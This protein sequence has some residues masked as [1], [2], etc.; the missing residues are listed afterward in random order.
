M[1]N[2]KHI[3]KL[4]LL[5]VF[6][7]FAAMLIQAAA[8]TQ[9]IHTP[10]ANSRISGTINLIVPVNGTMYSCNVAGCIPPFANVS[11]VGV[12]YT[13]TSPSGGLETG[14]CI[15]RSNIDNGTLTNWTCSFNTNVLEDIGTYTFTA[16]VYNGTGANLVQRNTTTSTGVTVDNFAPSAVFGA[17]TPADN[18]EQKA[19]TVTVDT[20]ADINA[21]SCTLFVGAKDY[22]V[23]PSGDVCSRQLSSLSD[24]S[25]T[26]Y[27]QTSDGLNS[28]TGATRTL[29]I[30]AKGV[31]GAAATEITRQA[32]AR[33]QGD[34]TMLVIIGSVIVVVVVVGGAFGVWRLTKG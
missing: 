12:N 33:E 31:S 17:L 8:I 24:G 2:R 34:T 13:R 3:W 6:S 7:V 29:R 23:T 11:Q 26:I 25:Y 20:E 19:N 5:E 4:A 14:G 10:A 21:T 28:T 1:V 30:N 16:Y 18:V 32:V 27:W 15:N 22:D 9:E